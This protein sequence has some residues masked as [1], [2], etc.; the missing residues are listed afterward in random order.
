MRPLTHYSTTEGTPMD[1]DL[2]RAPVILRED[3]QSP[4]QVRRRVATIDQQSAFGA[5]PEEGPKAVQMPA[6]REGPKHGEQLH[7]KYRPRDLKDVRGHSA[8]VQSL[9]AA[10]HAKSRPHSFL[11]TGPS[12]TGKTTL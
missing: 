8:I 6:L 2:T 3:L 12:R 10:L 5:E 7:T 4:R 11:F 1:Q 9:E